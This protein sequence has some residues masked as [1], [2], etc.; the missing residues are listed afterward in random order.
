[1]HACVCV[2]GRACVCVC[3][4]VNDIET[5]YLGVLDPVMFP[6]SMI[7]YEFVCECMC[8]CVCHSVCVCVGGGSVCV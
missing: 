1:M 7:W 5:M 2:C 4:C 3:V 8:V 6:N